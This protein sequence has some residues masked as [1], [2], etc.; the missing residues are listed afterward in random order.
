[1]AAGGVVGPAAFVSAW[2]AVGATRPGYSPVHDAISRLAAVGAPGRGWM[3]AGFVVFGLA[4]SAYATVV[5]RRLPGLAWMSAA[6]TALATL[7]VGA[8]PLDRTAT[9]DRLHAAA[10][11]IGYVT[12]AAIPL[13]AASAMADLAGAAWRHWSWA[14]AAVAAVLLAASVA[15]LARGLTQRTGLLAGDVWLAASACWLLTHE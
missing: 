13:L 14:A 11:V 4:V 9:V 7:L 12:L 6:A 15:G 2:A 3:T 5:R 10:A 1:L 8:L